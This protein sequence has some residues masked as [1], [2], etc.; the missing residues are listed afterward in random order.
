MDVRSALRRRAAHRPKTFPVA[1]PGA[2]E[3]RLAVEAGLRA[4]GWPTA[5]APADADL[6]VVCG[7]PDPGDADWIDRVEAAMP[8]PAV[9]VVVPDVARA[10]HA[11]D[12]GMARLAAGEFGPRVQTTR[13]APGRQGDRSAD[14]RRPGGFPHDHRG[15]RE[16]AGHGGRS[17][18]VD[19]EGTTGHDAGEVAGVPM[20]QRADDR[21][22]LRLDRLHVPLGPALA[23]WP[24]GL[25]LRLALQGDVVQASEVA[26]LSVRRAGLPYW[27]E[28]WLRAARGDEIAR[29]SAA[30]R[31]CAAHLDSVGRLLAV[32]G[33][34]SV[35]ARCRRLRDAA[36]SGASSGSIG[37]ELVA[38]TARIGRSRAL[39]WGIAGLGR[40]SAERARAAGVTGPAL[41]ADGDA[42]DRLRLW[43]DE[44]MCSFDELDDIRPLDP[45]GATG[46]R[47]S[48]DGVRPP[49]AA[50]LDIV[51]ELVDGTEFACARIIVASLDPDLDELVLAPTS[52]T[53]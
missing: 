12:T 40:L 20:A 38:T 5:G 24:A 28:P 34:D 32:A 25:V 51:P 10:A 26:H 35:A 41:T 21:D 52:G 13:A 31:R 29:G 33:W 39:R 1:L 3:S 42:H 16:H 50:L 15:D 2:T 4:R 36:L 47:G 49:S 23:D 7:A 18:P 43:L 9:R 8:L 46:P 27:D 53:D 45:D 11:L 30:R 37:T 48:L 6:L 22:G 14:R 44:I 17:A 19:H